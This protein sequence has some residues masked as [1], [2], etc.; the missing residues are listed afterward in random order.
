MGLLV[1]AGVVNLAAAKFDAASITDSV[2]GNNFMRLMPFDSAQ[3]LLCSDGQALAS[4]RLEQ[5]TPGRA[6][7]LRRHKVFHN[8][9]PEQIRRQHALCQDEVVEGLLVEIVT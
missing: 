6:A 3:C 8:G 5:L 4:G 7:P 2:I 1:L 9:L